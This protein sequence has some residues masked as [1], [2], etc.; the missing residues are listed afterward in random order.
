MADTIAY[1]QDMGLAIQLLF[2]PEGTDRDAP[3]IARC[4]RYCEKV[5]LQMYDQVLHPKTTGFV[6]LVQ[7]MRRLSYL[8]PY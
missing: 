4:T 2:F 7:Q 1:F 3:A 6:F 8:D 5:G